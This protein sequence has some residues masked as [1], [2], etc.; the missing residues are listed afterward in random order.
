MF[1]LVGCL[2][3]FITTVW[4]AMYLNNFSRIKILLLLP[5]IF[6]SF[7][8]WFDVWKENILGEH[9]NKIKVGFKYGIILFIFS[10]VF[11]FWGFFWGFFHNIFNVSDLIV[12]FPPQFFE[13]IILNPL[14]LPLLKTVLL[15]ISGVSVTLVHHS[16]KN[17]KYKNQFFLRLCITVF[18]GVL[19]LICQFLEYSLKFYKLK[20]LI[21][22]SVFYLLTG[23]HGF[24]VFVGVI[25]L[26]TKF[27][28]NQ[29][30]NSKFSLRFRIWYWHFVD[31]VWLFLFTY[32]YWYPNL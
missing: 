12:Y 13:R 4:G 8:W 23:F 9:I 19:F 18:F 20:S 29:T 14:M 27:I 28:L 30:N 3:L 1:P 22:G 16:I 25:F 21:F 5:L 31:V 24:H 15:L 17:F 7:R 11:F 32:I 2:N 10:E 26:S 6:I